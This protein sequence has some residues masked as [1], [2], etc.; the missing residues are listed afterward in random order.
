MAAGPYFPCF[1]SATNGASIIANFGATNFKY[2]KPTGFVGLDAV[3]S[4]HLDITKE[5]GWA[6]TGLPNTSLSISKMFGYAIVQD[7]PPYFDRRRRLDY[8]RK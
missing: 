6:I 5:L 4:T 1:G 3:T 2:P 7:R 8:L